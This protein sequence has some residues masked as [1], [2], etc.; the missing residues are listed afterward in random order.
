MCALET[1]WPLGWCIQVWG[2]SSVSDATFTWPA[3]QASTRVSPWAITVARPSIR[4]ANIARLVHDN[5]TTTSPSKGGQDHVANQLHAWYSP[6]ARRGAPRG[7]GGSAGPG[8]GIQEA[9]AHLAGA[10]QT[11]GGH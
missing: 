5:P 9:L 6:I 10:G 7:R 4:N 8:S 2:M 3:R 1:F 11:R